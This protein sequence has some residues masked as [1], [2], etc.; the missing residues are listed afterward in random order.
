MPIMMKFVTDNRMVSAISKIGQ[1]ETE[2]I[3]KKI[4]EEFISDVFADLFEAD[5]RNEPLWEACDQNQKD[6]VMRSLRAKTQAMI[7]RYK[8][9]VMNNGSDTE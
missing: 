2:D 4:E 5:E 1:P 6:I 9:K 7:Q 3:E 8:K